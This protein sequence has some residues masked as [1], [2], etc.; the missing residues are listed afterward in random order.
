MTALEIHDVSHAYRKPALRGVSFSIEPGDFVLLLGLNGA[1]KTTLF[2]LIAGLLN[3]QQ[4]SIRMLGHALPDG[5]SAALAGCGF[6]FQQS[7][8]DLDL[9]VA[10]SLSYH[11]ALH[12][13]SRASARERI[14]QELERFGLVPRMHDLVSARIFGS[15]RKPRYG[16]VTSPA[17][18]HERA[19][20][21]PSTRAYSCSVTQRSRA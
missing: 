7:A 11:A 5:R 10:Q 20:L 13:L 9:T 14:E 4:G 15:G 6:V 3:L 16:R 1:G 2:S 21:V 8:L 18:R 19:L 17:L 12:G